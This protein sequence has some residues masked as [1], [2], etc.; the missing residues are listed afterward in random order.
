[1]A[2]SGSPGVVPEM[3]Q[4]LLHSLLTLEAALRNKTGQERCIVPAG[5]LLR[6]LQLPQCNRVPVPRLT[7]SLGKAEVAG[8]W[9][10]RRIE[11]IRLCESQPSHTVSPSY[12]T[13]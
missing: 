9:P 11:R 6:W 10:R 5:P 12:A 1:E 7:A 4:C 3:S 2:P 8:R 13:S